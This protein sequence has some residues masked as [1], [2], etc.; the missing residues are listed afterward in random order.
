MESAPCPL[1]EAPAE[2]KQ[3]P[4]DESFGPDQFGRVVKCPDCGYFV[5]E[6]SV[7]SGLGRASDAPHRRLALAYALRRIPGN[8]ARPYLNAS[9]V[10][11]ILA[12]TRLPQPQE[13]P[14]EFVRFLGRSIATPGEL[15]ALNASRLRSAIGAPTSKAAAWAV[16]GTAAQNLLDDD[17]HLSADG[18]VG[19]ATLSRLGWARFDELQRQRTDLKQAF[20]A[21][22][23]GCRNST[24]W[25]IIICDLP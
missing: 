10:A 12:A 5:L 15:L 13:L 24:S 6:E 4:L 9:T 8:R 21:S 20:W 2:I 19:Q 18:V 25:S 7:L 3:Q 14:D 16:W 11:S 17:F 1:C 23:Y 22:K